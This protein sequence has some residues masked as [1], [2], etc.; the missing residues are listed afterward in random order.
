M[1]EKYTNY[2]IDHRTYGGE[3]T[4]FDFDRHHTMS[5]MAIKVA[6]DLAFDKYCQKFSVNKNKKT[7]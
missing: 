3:I 4:P 7:K 2:K 6:K 5:S 1:T